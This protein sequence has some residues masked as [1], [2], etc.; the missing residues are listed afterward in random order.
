M[1]RRI[2]KRKRKLKTKRTSKKRKS[3]KRRLLLRKSRVKVKRKSRVK[4]RFRRFSNIIG[5]KFK[6]GM[7]FKFK[8]IPSSGKTNNDVQYVA[9]N[10]NGRAVIYFQKN[11]GSFL[12]LQG[13][14]PI[15]IVSK[16]VLLI[17]Q[18]GFILYGKWIKVSGRNYINCS[19]VGLN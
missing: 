17:S 8:S 11:N 5:S 10:I 4:R 15:N 12:R 16:K 19:E 3:Y 13:V 7:C 6:N 2:S 9:K 18:L 1:V 14:E